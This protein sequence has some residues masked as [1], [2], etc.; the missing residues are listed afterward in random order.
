[1]EENDLF[2]KMIELFDQTSKTNSEEF[3]RIAERLETLNETVGD[4]IEEL[5]DFYMIEKEKAAAIKQIEAV[6][7]DDGLASQVCRGIRHG[8]FGE[9]AQGD[10]SLYD[11]VNGVNLSLSQLVNAVET[12][13]DVQSRKKI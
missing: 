10:A 7:T 5:Y 8:L 6:I 13:I 9:G 3:S 11:F 2:K 4:Y 12:L 1:M